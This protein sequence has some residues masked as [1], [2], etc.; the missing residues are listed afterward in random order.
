MPPPS[1][2]I[3]LGLSGGQRIFGPGHIRW[4]DMVIICCRWDS[5]VLMRWCKNQHNV[6]L[7]VLRTCTRTIRFK[8]RTDRDGTEWSEVI[9]ERSDH[10]WYH[11]GGLHELV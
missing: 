4:H 5:I 8:G 2:L 9:P 6:Q 7:L 11:L 10:I 1:A 3:S